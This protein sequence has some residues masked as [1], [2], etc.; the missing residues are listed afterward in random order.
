MKRASKYIVKKY[1]QWYLVNEDVINSIEL[2]IVPF[3][4]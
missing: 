2:V 3:P 4:G 1:R